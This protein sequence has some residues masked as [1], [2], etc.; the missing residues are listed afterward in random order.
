MRTSRMLCEHWGC[1]PTRREEVRERDTWNRFLST[2]FRGTTAPLWHLDLELLVP[3]TVRQ[4]ICVVSLSHSWQESYDKFSVFESKDISL[5]TKVRIVKAMVFSVVMYRC[6]SWPIKVEHQGTDAFELENPLD[7]KEIKSV[8][9]KGNQS[10]I[11]IGRTDAEA[12]APILWALDAKSQFTRRDPDA[13]KDWRQEE[14]RMTE[15]EIIGWHH[16]F[17]GH[18]LGQTLGDGE[19]QGSLECCIPW[20]CRVRQDLVTEQQQLGHSVCGNQLRCP[21]LTNTVHVC[22]HPR[23]AGCNWQPGPGKFPVR[24]TWD[25]AAFYLFIGCAGSLLPHTDFLYLQQA[26]QLL[27][28]CM[29]FSLQWL[30]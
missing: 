1:A 26:G 29:G 25:C 15:D 6:E 13:G 8:H 9:P 19:G 24:A 16:Q 5:L 2:I 30:L 4:S 11:F 18:E 10:W 3:R 21:E 20:G 14:K 12:G 23:A 27:L 17:K 22:V 28:W 7:F